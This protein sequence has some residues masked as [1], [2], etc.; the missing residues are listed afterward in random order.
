MD[1]DEEQSMNARWT[2][3]QGSGLI[4]LS[5]ATRG[6]PRSRNLVWV[7]VT[8]VISAFWALSYLAPLDF[9]VAYNRKLYGISLLKGIAYLDNGPQLQI[10]GI[11]QHSRDR[12]KRR[13]EQ[14]LA[15]VTREISDS[16]LFRNDGI[17]N[18]IEAPHA[19]TRREKEQRRILE[20]ELQQAQEVIYRLN[21]LVGAQASRISPMTV[22]VG[23]YQIS[24]FIA[25]VWAIH[26]L[27][28]RLL[29]QLRAWRRNAKG[30]CVACG[31]DLRSSEAICPECGLRITRM[32]RVP[33]RNP[34]I[35]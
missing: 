22:S 2:I 3:G 26:V 4:G 33:T 24:G 16:S 8:I 15:A 34:L 32:A 7:G 18:G 30:L 12:A 1:F 23:F 35:Y 31:Y 6:R 27:L 20:G 5:K 14:R 10:E 11:L 29:L 9:I 21:N 25:V 13:A 19:L 17:F 28:P